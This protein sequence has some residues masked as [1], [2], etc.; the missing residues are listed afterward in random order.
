MVRNFDQAGYHETRVILLVFALALSLYFMTKKKYKN[1]LIIFF[2]SAI[3]FGIVELIL[4]ILGMRGA[5]NWAISIFG[6]M[7]P[8][9][10]T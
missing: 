8:S 9:Y 7:I 4:I 6:V 2:S 3:F 1:Y 5:E 10:L